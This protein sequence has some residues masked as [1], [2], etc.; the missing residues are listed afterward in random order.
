MQF[1]NEFR[2][3][4]IKS[5][6]KDRID[7]T[8]LNKFELACLPFKLISVRGN[9]RTVKNMMSGGYSALFLNP[10]KSCY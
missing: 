5:N 4:A 6:S 3:F 8:E 1:D 10:I 7:D 9:K 2:K